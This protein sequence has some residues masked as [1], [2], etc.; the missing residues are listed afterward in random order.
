MQESE[1]EAI[2]SGPAP[3]PAAAESAAGRSAEETRSKYLPAKARHG[4]ALCLSGGGFRAALFHLGAVRRLNELGI[5]AR[6]DEISAVS[7]GSIFAA[8]LAD[9]LRPWPLPGEIVSDWEERIAVP[10]RAFVSQ[11]LR[12]GPA[13]LEWLGESVWPGLGM[14]AGELAQQYAERLTGMRLA[15]LPERPHFVFCATDVVFGVNWVS[16][17]THV[18]DYQAGYMV[19]P[20][21]WTVARAV[22]ASSCF[23]PVFNPL[24]LHVRP[25]ELTGGK[26]P[27]GEARDECIADLA[28]SD[29]GLYDNLALEPV[30][31][32]AAT[33]LVSDGGATFDHQPVRGL[34]K[35]LFRY[36]AVQGN[37]VG[38]LRKR[39]LIS[40]Y[41]EGV[42]R[43]TYWGIGSPASKYGLA[44]WTGYSKPLVEDVISE[45]R[46]DMDAFS[47][48]EIS[49][50]ENHGYMTAAVALRKH[51]PELSELHPA[52]DL[53]AVPNPVWL[54]EW[55]VRAAIQGTPGR[56]R[57]R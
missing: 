18:G 47:E 37:Q 31:R 38:A 19:P 52:A 30:W 50:I 4:L 39:W 33:L 12:S 57:A 28:L 55:R 11:D 32:R 48:G 7:G 45:V 6:V 35:R 20:D 9:R 36:N 41:I 15:D 13:I 27:K 1:P 8:H 21:D 16:E 46:T 49:V 40:N 51:A 54:E 3:I 17:R 5:L 44:D 23:P 53:I 34:L 2:R 25:E 56:R 14:G 42:L 29:G 26:V 43:G 24:P 22:A 10:F